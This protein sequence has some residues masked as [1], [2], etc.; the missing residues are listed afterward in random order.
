MELD[1]NCPF[2]AYCLFLDYKDK[3]DVLEPQTLKNLED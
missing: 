1:K 2:K 3:A